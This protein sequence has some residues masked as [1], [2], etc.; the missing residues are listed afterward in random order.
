[1][2]KSRYYR[3]LLYL[4]LL[5]CLYLLFRLAPVLFSPEVMPAD[6]FGHFWASGK[7]LLSGE[8]PYNAARL[9]AL[10]Q[11]ISGGAYATEVTSLTL[12]PPW[13][14]SLLLPFSLLPYQAARLAWLIMGILLILLSIRAIWSL[15]QGDPHK[16]W[17]AWLVGLTFAPTISVLTKGQV[18]VWLLAATAGFVLLVEKRMNYWLAALCCVLLSIKPQLFYLFWPAVGLWMLY[19]RKWKL[20]ATSLCILIAATL[21][22][23]ALNPAIFSQYLAAMQAYPASAWATPTIGAYL[24]FFWLG[25]A[26]FWVQYVPGLICAVWLIFRYHKHRHTWKWSEEVPAL[27]LLSLITSPYAWTYDQV[28]LIPAILAASAHLIRVRTWLSLAF[29]LIYLGINILDLILHVRLSEFWFLWLAPAYTI[30]Y[31][32]VNG[33]LRKHN[34]QLPSQ[35]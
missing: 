30:W 34:T 4:L 5:S 28:L 18:T 17:A 3:P 8:N 24:R 27:L 31:L 2:R 26:N 13:A 25:E 7:L 35:P 12:N 23:L 10:Q 29:W 19:S 9:V 11:Q 16:L 20:L 15:Y 14:L 1:M 22:V 6:D 33:W 32:G 21:P